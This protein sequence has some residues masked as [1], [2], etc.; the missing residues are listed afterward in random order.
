MVH[1]LERLHLL[2]LVDALEEG[3]AGGVRSSADAI[4]KPTR[5]RACA[6]Q[7]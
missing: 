4:S 2:Q 3:K 7:Q 5:T 1:T 6:V